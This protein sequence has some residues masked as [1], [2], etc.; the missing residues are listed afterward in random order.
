MQKEYVFDY[1]NKYCR[2]MEFA[3]STIK[4]MYIP[5]RV[6]ELAEL[7]CYPKDGVQHQMLKD[8]NIGSCNIIDT[9]VLGEDAQKLGLITDNGYFL[10]NNRFIVDIR[11]MKNNLI[12]LVGYY[13]DFKKY[14]TTPSQFFAKEL[15]FFNIA[16]AYIRSWEKFDG[17]VFLVEG[18]FDALSLK[19]IG[20]PVI[21][22][23]GVTVDTPKDNLLR[24]FKKV[25]GIPDNDK[26]GRRCLNR[27]DKKYGWKLDEK[28]IFIRLKG[29]L[30]TEFGDLPIKDV[31]NM[32]T[33]LGAK[34]TYN[35]LMNYAES[36]ED[37]V[38]DFSTLM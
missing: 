25:V 14:I 22:T 19:A 12:A 35:I 24:F 3:Y 11:D 29:K 27:Y 31:D 5:E 1:Y 34:N 33:V 15:C 28:D 36:K 17:T 23:M 2:S 30:H 10:L 21:G 37:V 38:L 6:D 9:T 7:R 26:A 32:V 20:L 18:M 16:E 13:P 8:F 4:K